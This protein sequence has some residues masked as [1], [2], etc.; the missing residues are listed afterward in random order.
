MKISF[1]AFFVAGGACQSSHAWISPTAKTFRSSRL[2]H[3]STENAN[4]E[5]DFSRWNRRQILST[6]SSLVA[7]YSFAAPAMALVKGNAPP[8]KAK[9]AG[10]KPKCTNVEECQAQAEILEAQRAAEAAAAMEADTATQTTVSGIRYRDLEPG[11]GLEAKIGDDVEIFYKVLK[12]GKRSY[13]GLSG[14]GTVVFSRGYGLEDDEKIPGDQ[15]FFTTLGSLGNIVALNEAIP[16]MKEGGIR[17]FVILPDKVCLDQHAK[18]PHHSLNDAIEH[19]NDLTHDSFL[20]MTAGLEK[21]RKA[22]R[23]RTWWTRHGWGVENRLCRG[24]YS[25]H[26]KRRSLL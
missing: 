18:K 10:D 1:I 11:S 9:P 14:E 23:R 19:E 20:S 13:D 17:R 25:N 5:V 3:S 15:K 2:F 21:A 26:G 7:G 4:S 12:L 16:G 8:P 24:S 22:M 6:T